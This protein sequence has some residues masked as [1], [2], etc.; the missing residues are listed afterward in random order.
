MTP[1][2]ILQKPEFPDT[3]LKKGLYDEPRL[4]AADIMDA[5]VIHLWVILFLEF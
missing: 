2:P 1:V 5:K 3:L 4:C